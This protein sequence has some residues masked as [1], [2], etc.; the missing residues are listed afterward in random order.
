[1]KWQNDT[2]QF[3]V[4]VYYNIIYCIIIYYIMVYYNRQFVIIVYYIIILTKS[5]DTKILQ[6]MKCLS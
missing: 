5:L 1:M 4:I 2:R 6:E 3:E